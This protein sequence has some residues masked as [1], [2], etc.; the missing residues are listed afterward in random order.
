MD[1][2]PT[3]A[4]FEFRQFSRAATIGRR[5]LHGGPLANH[6][7]ILYVR[8]ALQRTS[9]RWESPHWPLVSGFAMITFT[10]GSSFPDSITHSEWGLPLSTRDTLSFLSARRSTYTVEGSGLDA[11]W[12]QI[13]ITFPPISTKI[14]LACFV[15]LPEDIWQRWL[16]TRNL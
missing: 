11:P 2:S 10:P 13:K 8:R 6:L 12:K 14:G 16:G 15:D 5:T 1:L 9:P 4:L 7:S 3:R